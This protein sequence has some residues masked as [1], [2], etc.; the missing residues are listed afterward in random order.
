M[1]NLHNTVEQLKKE[2][3]ELQKKYDSLKKETDIELAL[4]KQK[5]E[6]LE[7]SERQYRLLFTKAPLGYQ[8][9]D[10]D[11][12]FITVNQQWL[13]TMGYEREEVEGKWFG[14]FLLP[15]QRELFR[16]R[17]LVFKAQG[18][19]YS[20][21]EMLHKNGRKLYVVFNGRIGCDID[22]NFK[23]THCIIQDYTEKKRD[24]DALRESEENL[25]ITLNS[26]GD[27][28]IS[29]DK[30][31]FIVS[32][33]TVAEK[34]CGWVLH[35][36]IGKPLTDVF[37]IYNAITRLPVDNPV[38]TVIKNGEIVGLANHTVL[39]SKDGREYQIA[40]SAAPIKNRDGE[41]CGVVL[42]FSDV[43]EKYLAHQKIAESEERYRALLQNLEAGIVV[44]APDTSVIMNN[45]RAAE[46][47][48]LSDSQMKGKTAAFTGWKFV[49]EWNRDMAVE[50]YP[51]MKILTTKKPIRNQIFGIHH[52]HKKNIVW[53]TV[54]GFP[55]FDS[56]KQV[57]E[58]VISF[59]DFTERKQFE[60]MLRDEK[61]RIKTILE[62]VN[63]PIFVK[64]NAHRITFANKAFYELFALSEKD[65]LGKTLAEYIPENELKHF[66]EVDR[67]V[68]DTGITDRREEELTT[69]GVVHTIITSKARFIDESGEL[70]MVGSIHDIT[71]R[72][73]SEKALAENEEKYRL[74]YTAMDQGL[75]LHEVI[76]DENGKPIDYVFLDIND[77]YTRLLGVTR[78]MAIGKR[79]KEVM[80]KVEQYWIDVFGNVALTGEPN[81]YEDYL[82]TT[83]RFY[84]TYSYSPKKNQ[85][86]VLV[87]DITEKKLAN[88]EL[89]KAKEKAQ[90][91]DRLKSA[92]LANMS[93]EIRTPM[94]GIL[95]FAELLKTP[96]LTGTK[97]K[98]YI[99]II[100][101]SG[102]RMLNI[103]N[104]I[105]DISKIESGLIQLNLKESNVNEQLDYI[106]SFFKTEMEQ[107]G[108]DFFI[109]SPLSHSEAFVNTDKEKF[110]AILINLVKNAFKYTRQGTIELG[111]TVVNAVS[112]SHLQFYV[113][114]T[115]VG[116]GKER[117][118]AIF[119]RFIQADIEDKMADQGAGL[120]LAI[121]KSYVE[122]LGGKIWVESEL[123]VGSTFYF[124]LPYTSHYCTKKSTTEAVS[125]VVGAGGLSLPKLKILIAEDDEVS[126]MLLE[127]AMKRFGEEVI[128]V[129]NGVDAVD[130]C[131]QNDDID[132]VLMDIQMPLLNGYEATK[133]IREFNSKV[134]IVAQTA[135]AQTTDLE[136][137][138]AA[139]CN[140]HIAKP[141]V[142]NKLVALLMKYFEK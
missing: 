95:G 94:N 28:V 26:I 114:D 79:I 104:D 66:L 14:D 16:K 136:K 140:D 86:A 29:T 98:E 87:S 141:I 34:L 112:S 132:L 51:V 100:K 9:L 103:I 107:K 2:L 113:K 15:E 99:E 3:K 121:S 49:D 90:E 48:G 50:D 116:I 129:K 33:N 120:G 80:P 91:S 56:E 81:Y 47:L 97:Q 11:G 96:G 35:E 88:E 76:T 106:Y 93:H 125:K 69:G 118:E 58:V 61:S 101:K 38:K 42:V 25:S 46:L 70:F 45:G 5:L 18:F 74:L 72:K 32:M 55:F 63:D 17:F 20:E 130:A 119:E 68:L 37:N 71:E 65:V 75:A 27:G 128:Y 137:A 21:F 7:E 39:V 92:F 123:G 85:F 64:D 77:S 124:T 105:I 111:F 135:Y 108:I 133:Q 134:I 126:Q 89:I 59:V 10:A 102:D 115:G 142:M 78:E 36:A 24:E 117:Q 84:S 110:Y 138:I 40:D 6:V 30:N 73:Q 82:E 13:D 52:P 31:G 60:T 62:L 23:Q 109:K 67:V 53:V 54:S 131:R 22:G 1:E 12:N 122:M 43:T 83:G 8:A 19:I 4:Q 57:S 127:I 44:H 139:G 41:I